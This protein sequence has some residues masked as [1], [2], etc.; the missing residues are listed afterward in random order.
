MINA[1]FLN[2]PISNLKKS[3]EFFTA[4]GFTFNA[5]FTDSEGTCMIVNENIYVMLSEKRKFQSFIDKKIAEPDTTEVVLSLSCDSVA[6]VRSLAEKAF[7]A[8]GRKIN[9]PEDHG[10][11]FSWAFEDLDGHLWDLFWMNP[12][13][14]QS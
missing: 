3:V 14:V 5:Q 10:F 13:H 4:L 7:T 12:D 6:E 8:G 11:M 9:E 2:L 1:I